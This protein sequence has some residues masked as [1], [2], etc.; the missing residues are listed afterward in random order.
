MS[1]FNCR[2]EGVWEA[3]GIHVAA[4]QLLGGKFTLPSPESNQTSETPSQEPS[5]DE[6]VNLSAQENS[7]SENESD[8]EALVT[9]PPPEPESNHRLTK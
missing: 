4:E 6:R 8:G 7:E 3:L 2:P 9:D 5:P 1:M